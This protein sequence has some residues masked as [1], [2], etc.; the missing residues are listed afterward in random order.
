MSETEINKLLRQFD[1][2]GDGT[3][4]L[5]EFL[6][7]IESGNKRDVIQKALIQRAGIRK[8]F[9]KYDT[10][11][12]GAITRD[13]FRRLVEDKYQAKLTSIQIDE[14]MRQADV[15]KDGRINYEEFYKAFTYMPVKT[16]GT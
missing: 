16:V 6:A 13:E 3:I 10:D 7:F 8:S 1:K 5:K 11:G 15:N 2:N 9:Q 4:D 12:N 14:L